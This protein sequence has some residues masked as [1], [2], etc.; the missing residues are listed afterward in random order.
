MF[1]V[2]LVMAWNKKQSKTKQ[3]R[4]RARAEAAAK[5]PSGQTD[6]TSHSFY[7]SKYNKAIF[8]NGSS[9]NLV[10]LDLEFADLM[11]LILVSKTMVSTAR[12]NCAH[13]KKNYC[14]RSI[15][16]QKRKQQTEMPYAANKQTDI[17]AYV[18][19]YQ[20]NGQIIYL[21]GRLAGWLLDCLASSSSLL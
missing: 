14:R 5:K 17:R 6:E 12:N 3:S 13:T 20:L 11:N 4:T 1:C 21:A 18:R 19:T 16:M 9:K 2:K 10:R 8:F 7:P 15:H